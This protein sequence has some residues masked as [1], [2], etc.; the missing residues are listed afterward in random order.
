MIHRFLLS[1]LIVSTLSALPGFGSEPSSPKNSD[2]ITL[3]EGYVRAVP[4]SSENSAAYFTILNS[5]KK[6]VTLLKADS[7]LA[8]AVELHEH[9]HENGMMKMVQVPSIEVPAGES[10]ELEPMGLHIM[11]IGLKKPFFSAKE[12]VLK[13]SFSD[14]KS[15]TVRLPVKKEEE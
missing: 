5:G 12:I 14:G 10:V 8:R 2:T 3:K 6:S 9:R 11:M 13:L 7:S 1:A 15:R 4:A